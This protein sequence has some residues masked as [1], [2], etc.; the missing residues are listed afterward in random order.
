MGDLVIGR[1]QNVKLPQKITPQNA[2]EIIGQRARIALNGKTIP[3]G[4][5]VE[6]K[7]SAANGENKIYSINVSG[8]GMEKEA[9]EKLSSQIE[10]L[11]CS[12]FL[13]SPKES[14]VPEDA[15]LTIIKK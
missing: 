3:E 11:L 4:T 12:S 5:S 15:R 6:V 8:E 1:S 14:I 9:Q 13:I 10:R 2:G 7:Y